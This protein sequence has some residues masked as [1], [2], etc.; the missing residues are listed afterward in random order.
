MRK[1]REVP[2]GE[3]R[4]ARYLVKPVRIKAWGATLFLLLSVVSLFSEEA[5]FFNKTMS[6]KLPNKKYQ[7]RVQEQDTCT[8]LVVQ[9]PG[10]KSETLQT[11]VI[12]NFAIVAERV[13]P[14]VSTMDYLSFKITFIESFPGF[15][16]NP[17]HDDILSCGLDGSISLYYEYYDPKFIMHS[18]YN[19]LLVED[20]VAFHILFDCTSDLYPSQRK[21]VENILKS[22]KLK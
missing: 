12:P 5:V 15:N 17:T 13:P 22:L 10:K 14:T 11:V 3:P 16:T 1:T 4:S 2:T 18:V 6:Y 7:Q 21:T 20:D 9:F 8:S 19:V